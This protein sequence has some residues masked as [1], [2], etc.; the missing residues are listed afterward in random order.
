[1]TS[2]HTRF[3]VAVLSCSSFQC[4]RRARRPVWS[5]WSDLRVWE[6]VGARAHR[7]ED[8][9]HGHDSHVRV[10]DLCEI[11]HRDYAQQRGEDR[12]DERSDLPAFAFDARRRER[13]AQV[14]LDLLELFGDHRHGV[15]QAEEERKELAARVRAA[16]GTGAW[17]GESSE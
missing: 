7:L 16:R 4:V 14:R 1:M 3:A 17:T 12:E 6:G 5:I 10:K 9:G 15:R 8:A 13:A 2:R 11:C